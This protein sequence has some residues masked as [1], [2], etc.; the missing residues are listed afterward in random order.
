MA[1]F[2]PRLTSKPTFP[3][4]SPLMESVG[5]VPSPSSVPA[6]A[7]PISDLKNTPRNKKRFTPLLIILLAFVALVVG[8]VFSRLRFWVVSSTLF[9][10]C[11]LLIVLGQ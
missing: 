5:E 3:P 8:G 6:S 9:R 11:H 10:S 1:E 2:D 4:N 7:P